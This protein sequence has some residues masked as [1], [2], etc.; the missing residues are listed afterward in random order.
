M[1]RNCTNPIPR[2]EN[3]RLTAQLSRRDLTC[4][5]KQTDQGSTQK[6]NNC[7][8]LFTQTEAWNMMREVQV[9]SEGYLFESKL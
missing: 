7:R 2:G 6:K 9:W 1:Y 8:F 5:K 3:I 4:G